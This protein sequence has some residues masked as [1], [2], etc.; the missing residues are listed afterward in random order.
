MRTQSHKLLLAL[1]G[2]SLASCATTKNYEAA[3]ST[4]EGVSRDSLIRSW[5]PPD[6]RAN[7]DDGEEIIEYRK[8][9]RYRKEDNPGEGGLAYALGYK[10]GEWMA[11]GAKPPGCKTRFLISSDGVINEYEYIGE[12]CNADTKTMSRLSFDKG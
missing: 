6:L 10:L 7:L 4:W 2:I 8:A 5:G 11:G 1:V 12:E 3:L 9:S